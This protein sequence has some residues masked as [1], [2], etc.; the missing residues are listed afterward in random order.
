MSFGD[1]RTKRIARA[2]SS[3]QPDVGWGTRFVFRG[4]K[5]AIDGAGGKTDKTHAAGWR[6]AQLPAERVCSYMSGGFRIP[7]PEEHFSS[8]IQQ[9][10]FL[11]FFR[12]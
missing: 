2:D 1:L 4:V 12:A 8:R 10:L 9:K 7:S 5:A 11:S 3:G 6:A